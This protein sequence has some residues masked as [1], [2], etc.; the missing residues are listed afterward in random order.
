MLREELGDEVAIFGKAYGP[1]SLAYHF[2]GI[3]PFLM[4]TFRS[5]WT[6]R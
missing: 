2:F 4:D 3:E 6:R 5:F 1:C